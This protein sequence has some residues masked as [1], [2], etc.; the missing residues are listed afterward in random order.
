MLEQLKANVGK[1][2]GVELLN[3]SKIFG[4]LLDVNEKIL[5]IDCDEGIAHLLVDSIQIVWENVEASLAEEDIQEILGKVKETVETRYVCLGFN[6]FRCP[7]SYTCRP[8]HACNNFFCPGFFS[9]GF[10]P[11]DEPCVGQFFGYKRK[12]NKNTKE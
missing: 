4:I 7:Q 2:I 5:R 1:E 12:G 6:G 3:G 8:P 10:V 9:S 11:P